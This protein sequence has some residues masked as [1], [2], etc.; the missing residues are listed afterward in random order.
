MDVEVSTGKIK[1]VP[2]FLIQGGG[3]QSGNLFNAWMANM[4]KDQVDK[5]K[6]EKKEE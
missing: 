2:D 5:K 4:V 6:E 3:E 1:I